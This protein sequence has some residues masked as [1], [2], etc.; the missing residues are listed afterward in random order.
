MEQ[1]DVVKRVVVVG[2]G[3]A[4]F[5]AAIT[6][7][8]RARDLAVTVIRSKEIGIIGVGEGSTA[9]LPG[10]L[11]G[12]LG[13][14]YKDFYRL[15]DPIWKLGIKFLW[16]KRPFF[17]YSF[18]S[19]FD[20]PLPGLSRIAAYYMPREGELAFTGP[21]AA[22]MTM[23][24]AF[25]R[26]TDGLPHINRGLA[27]HL[28]NEKFVRFLE[29]YATRLG[30]EIVDDTIVEVQQD[31]RGVSGLR[32]AS[33]ST[34]TGD[35]YI[36]S[37]GFQSLLMSRTFGEP[38]TSFKSS[39]FCDRAV[40]G[41]WQREQ[42]PIMPYTTAETMNS[43]W[44]WQIEH[45]HRINRGYVYSSAF[46]S[47][48]EAER[49]FRQKN[50]KVGPTR[51]VKFVTGRYA[52]TWVKNVV[53]IGNASGFVEPLESTSLSFICTESLWLIE[54]LLDAG[55]QVRPSVVAL[56]NKRVGKAWDIIRQFLALHYK[57]NDRLDTPFWRECREK[58]DVCDAGEF[59]DFFRENG[60]SPLWVKTLLHPDDQFQM[61]GYLAMLV[62][63]A[64]PYH[65]TFVPSEGERQAWAQA[66]RR[67]EAQARAGFD[68]REAL[69]M[70]RSP[71]FQFP[72]DLYPKVCA[73]APAIGPPRQP[74]MA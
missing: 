63:Q 3:S 44:C 8:A 14:D 48:E 45:E 46:I 68:V 59:L 26:R 60:P 25:L 5:L 16:G 74:A 67:F 34:R 65:T 31:E 47:D 29:D 24:K 20:A 33:G 39:L 21:G 13:I 1:S 27:Y 50:P 35:L 37:S 32:L 6:L 4:G 66:Q 56:F 40:V 54:G 49:E 42:E 30:V 10:H 7:K 64:V 9:V 28:E 2:G 52:R 73:P 51:V 61:E 69:A 70:V 62:G 41:G 23:G 57:F 12:Y 36:D 38:F 15:A 55:R 72:Q 19:E 43:G 22:L 17:Y 53:A 71:R 11:H 58:T 18:V